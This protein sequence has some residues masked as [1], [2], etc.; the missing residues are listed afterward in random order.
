MTTK[1]SDEKT[2]KRHERMLAGIEDQLDPE[3]TMRHWLREIAGSGSPHE[4]LARR[5]MRWDERSPIGV[6]LARLTR[7]LALEEHESVREQ[8][9]QESLPKLRKTMRRCQLLWIFNLEVQQITKEASWK[10]DAAARLIRIIE[11]FSS[12]RSVPRRVKVSDPVSAELASVRKALVEGTTSLV[13]ARRAAEVF[14]SD[15]FQSEP[16]L[17]PSIERELL[18]QEQAASEA[19]RKFND[20]VAKRRRAVPRADALQPID[21][22]ALAGDDQ[23]AQDLVSRLRD[24]SKALIYVQLGDRARAFEVMRPHLFSV[25]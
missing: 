20:L 25:E 21:L 3:M 23:S 9:F 1:G 6:L 16:L 11:H 15:H 7:R 22:E 8:I 10:I 14:A 19:A 13:A 12:S 17:F 5:F 4:Y 24:F 18:A 2:E